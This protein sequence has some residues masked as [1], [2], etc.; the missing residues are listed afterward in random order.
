MEKIRGAKIAVIA[1]PTLA[2][3]VALGIS[4]LAS[5][6]VPRAAQRDM[7]DT[8]SSVA[9]ASVLY[10]FCGQSSSKTFC[11]DGANPADMVQGSDG[12]FYG[13]T[14]FG[15][16]NYDGTVFKLTPSGVLTSLHSF[17]S[18]TDSS[19][20]CLDGAGPGALVQ[21]SDGN[22]YG[23]TVRGGENDI[24]GYS[25]GAGTIFQITPAGTLTSLYS[26]CSQADCLDGG[27]PSGLVQG[28]DG[29]LYGTT[30][31][32]GT[33]DDGTVF[34]ITPAGVLTTIHSFSGPDGEIPFGGLVQATDGNFYGTTE[35][36]GAHDS[37]S[38]PNGGGTVF[39]ITPAGV[40]TPLYSFCGQTD[41]GDGENPFAL[42]VQGSDGNFYGTTDGGGTQYDEG[43][44]FRITP[45]GVLTTLYAFCSQNVSGDCLDG[46]QPN[47]L[48]QGSDGNLYGT[49]GGGGANRSG[50]VFELTPA[51]VLT[52]LYP[53]CSQTDGSGDC[54]DGAGPGAL[55]QGS[56]G[57]FYGA[58]SGGGANKHGGTVF[59][60]SVSAS[61]EYKL[62]IT[63]KKLNFGAL[64]IGQTRSRTVTIRNLG[65]SKRGFEAI[66]IQ[67]I[68]SHTGNFVVRSNGCMSTTL[69]PKGKGTSKAD[70]ECTATVVFYP[71]AGKIVGTLTISTG[72]ESQPTIEIPMTG[73]GKQPKN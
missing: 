24:L 16:A 42:L 58:T 54:L 72:L 26:F 68:V 67:S 40:L 48:I 36:G 18:Q 10:S 62:R 34:R 15:G 17:C 13:T 19:G 51:G 33:N 35:S 32:G 57:N 60:L 1:A 63:P 43:T 6:G 71:T 65:T 30:V 70:T 7:S 27:M 55:I 69:E 49:A 53:F 59:E 11:V 4:L 66:A 12:N 28:S 31:F 45:A 29:N 39:K 73:I 21:G 8:S 5:V 41:C 20:D 3:V 37:P 64:P 22:F 9:T 46:T 50:T 23:T 61:A 44:A 38:S 56:D 14:A 2:G 47:G 52:T 25:S